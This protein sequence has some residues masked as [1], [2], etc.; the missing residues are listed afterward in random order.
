MAIFYDMKGYVL[1]SVRDDILLSA[2]GWKPEFDKIRRIA[3]VRFEGVYNGMNF[4]EM[5]SH[6]RKRDK[7]EDVPVTLDSIRPPGT[8]LYKILMDD[9]RDIPYYVS[10][11][12]AGDPPHLKLSRKSTHMHVL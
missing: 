12:Y 4:L 5:A 11:F 3:A 1:N 6:Q 10:R 8:Y 9:G 7:T 2:N